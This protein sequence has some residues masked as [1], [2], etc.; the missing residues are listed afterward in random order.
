MRLFHGTSRKLLP[1]IQK[2]GI[3]RSEHEEWGRSDEFG[4][5]T[6]CAL[7]SLEKAKEVAG[8]F[9]KDGVVIEFEVPESVVK[10]HPDYGSNSSEFDTIHV[11]S[12]VKPSDIIRIIDAPSKLENTRP[13]ELSLRDW[14]SREMGKDPDFARKLDG[15][16]GIK[17]KWNTKGD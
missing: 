16:L 15:V 1:S 13:I 5:L 14:K 10:Y 7:D 4:S 3:R 9:G 8:Y 6:V 11:I 12:D 17:R 2:H